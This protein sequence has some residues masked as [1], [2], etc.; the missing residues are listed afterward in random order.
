MEEILWEYRKI[1]YLKETSVEEAIHQKKSEDWSFCI[2]HDKTGYPQDCIEWI[3]SDRMTPDLEPVSP[4]RINTSTV[5]EYIFQRKSYMTP[6]GKL[7]LRGMHKKNK[8]YYLFHLYKD[9]MEL[10]TMKEY[11]QYKKREMNMDEIVPNIQVKYL[12]SW[13]YERLREIYNTLMMSCGIE[14]EMMEEKEGTVQDRMKD[15]F[16]IICGLHT[17]SP[18]S[19][20]HF[21]LKTRYKEL[22]W[23]KEGRIPEDIV[24]PEYYLWT[25]DEQNRYR[26]HKKETEKIFYRVFVK[27]M[28]RKNIGCFSRYW[29]EFRAPVYRIPDLYID[30]KEPHTLRHWERV[31]QEK[32]EYSK[33]R[34]Q[35]E[36]RKEEALEKDIMTPS[37]PDSM[38]CP[39]W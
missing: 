21:C 2:V 37:L 28:Q 9:R 15:C 35:M 5:F 13:V 3:Q 25:R 19:K 7:W 29:K 30:P 14:E 26:E 31:C 34:K 36:S 27:R 11:D 6:E 33:Y 38:F 24:F 4:S 18:Y 10:M 16:E 8:P 39:I 22:V 32:K 20:Y 12:P 17:E 1:R 23:N